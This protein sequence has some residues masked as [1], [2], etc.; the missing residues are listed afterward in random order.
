MYS[1]LVTPPAHEPVTLDEAK[2]QCRVRHTE[3]D[4]LIADA[5]RAARGHAEAYLNS[6]LVRQTRRAYFD[7]FPS[8][9]GVILPR[10]PVIEV[11][12]IS[13]VDWSGNAQ[14]LAAGEFR[15]DLNPYAPA[16]WPLYDSY[17]PDARHYSGAIS[18]LYVAGHDSAADIPEDIRHAVLMLTE[19]FYTNRGAVNVGNIVSE[20]KIGAYGLLDLHRVMVAA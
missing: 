7:S 20:M 19:H 9:K 10:P 2:A 16:L 17:W 8:G 15:V 11:T 13:Y 1:V 12:E 5:I 18:A 6:S 4:E 14:T 3:E